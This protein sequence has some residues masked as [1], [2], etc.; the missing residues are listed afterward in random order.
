LE[1]QWEAAKF[2]RKT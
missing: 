1:F 2:M